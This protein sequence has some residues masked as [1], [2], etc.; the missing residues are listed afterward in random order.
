VELRAAVVAADRRLAADP[1]WDQR[2][3]RA[4]LARTSLEVAVHA[5]PGA[6]YALASHAIADLEAMSGDLPQALRPPLDRLRRAMAAATP[7]PEVDADQ[8]NL[9]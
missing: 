1:G 7:F 5:Q 3:P 6:L 8:L 4:V 2:H 9:D